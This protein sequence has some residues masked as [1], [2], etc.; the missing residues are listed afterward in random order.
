MVNKI[1]IDEYGKGNCCPNCGSIRISVMYQYPLL[2]EE[3]LKTGKEIIKDSQTGKRI[4]P[5]NR[6]LA[7]R[8]KLS[9]SDAQMW[10]FK[11][12]KCDWESETFVP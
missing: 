11:C 10:Q 4:K 7:H 12:R 3:D 1:P 2:V 5:T 9:Q 6:I 8:Y